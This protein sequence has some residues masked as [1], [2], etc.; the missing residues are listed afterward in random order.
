MFNFKYAMTSLSFIC[1]PFRA[2]VGPTFLLPLLIH[3]QEMA[4]QW[5]RVLGSH[6]RFVLLLIDLEV[7]SLDLFFVFP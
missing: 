5:F 7:S 6:L 1:F 2:M 4:M 3:A